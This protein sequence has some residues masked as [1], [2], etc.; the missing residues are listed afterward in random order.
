MYSK[1][2]TITEI[3]SLLNISPSTVSRALH[4]HSS[5]GQATRV[6]VRNLATQLNY[7]PNLSAISFQKGRN[8]T[9]GVILP[10]LSESFFSTVVSAIEDTAAKQ[11]YTVLIAQSHEN[12]EHEK[13]LVKR[14]KDHRVD[15]L[16]VSIAKNTTNIDHFQCLRNY[17]I[18]VVFFDRVPPIAQTHFVGCNIKTGT[19][20]AMNYLLKKGHRV[21]GMINGP[22]T[23]FACDE[24]REGYIEAMT[25]NRLKFDPT[26]IVN[27]DL[28]EQET[29]MAYRELLANKRKPTAIITFNDYLA[30]FAINYLRHS[31]NETDKDIEFVSYSNLPLVHYMD[32]VPAASV[33]QFPYLQ[34][35]KATD[36]LMQLLDQKNEN[37]HVPLGYYK[38]KIES[39]LV[40]SGKS[41]SIKGSTKVA[42]TI[43]GE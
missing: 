7:E 12:T 21:I 25:K 43:A 38:V 23:L 31:A 1:P 33:E 8:Y 29:L 28:T 15:G 11:N 39:Q 10:E 41:S 19:I 16:L 36:I 34:G 2:A 18:P 24:R 13:Q 26:M 14:M 22:K 32:A 27:C 30:L 17:N 20:E 5:I 9:I 3:A 37:N 42:A 6:K 4:D 35:Q 40:E